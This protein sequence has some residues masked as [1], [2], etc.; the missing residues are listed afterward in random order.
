MKKIIWAIIIIF[1]LSLLL[2]QIYF[3]QTEPGFTLAKVFRG[4]V[5]QEVSEVGKVKK[6]EEISLGFK[7]AGRIEKIYVGVGEGVKKGDILVKLENS[8]LKI[9]LEEAKANLDLAQAKLNKLL[10][11]ASQEEIQIAQTAVDNTQISLTTAEQ[12]L[13]DIKAQGEE[14]LKAAYEDA[15]NVLDDSY[16]KIQNAFNTADSVQRT[17][18]TKTDQEGVT[19]RDQKDK[20]ESA[21]NQ[22]KLYLDTAKNSQENEDI[23]IALSEMKK[24]LEVT[25]EALKI[26]RETCDEITY[27]DL[28][29]S[30]DKASLNTQRGY[31]NTA[32]T[33]VVNSQQTISSTKLT[34]TVNINSYQAKID[35]AQGKLKA[36]KDELA[37]IVAPPREEDVDLYQAQTRQA[38]A[39]IQ[40]LKNQIE[41]TILRSPVDGQVIGVHKR[42]GETVQPML[43]DSAISILPDIPFEIEVDIYEEDVAKMNIG[44][45]VDISLVAFPGIILKGEIISI[46]PAEKIIEGVVYYEVSIGFKEPP[47][48]VKPGM[49]AD[50]VIK[51]ASK[52][53][54]LIIPE[55]AIQKKNGKII[56]QVLRNEVIKE[57]EIEVGLEGSNGRVEVISGISEGEEI[58]I[59]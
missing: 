59:P 40:L 18:F 36:A 23:D 54:V 39:K 58:V 27:R 33:N 48:G 38:K 50:L 53:N 26:I 28:V 19:V 4:S 21:S 44:N 13:E 46:D 8:E 6:G 49:T 9:K 15:L 45:P 43:Q 14:D 41:D 24:A 57:R 32:L 12:D 56:V 31:I 30:T 25:A 47:A 16:L 29:S 10:A 17:Y 1:L 51:T 22:A 11:G 34:N 42:V 55:K 52:E 3:R 20:I 2:Y 5:F 7:N 37:Q 35:S